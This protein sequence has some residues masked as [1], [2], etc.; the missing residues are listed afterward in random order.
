VPANR[1]ASGE[2]R[3]RI[4]AGTYAIAAFTTVSAK[5]WRLSEKHVEVRLRVMNRVEVPQ[6]S[7]VVMEP[8][9]V[10]GK[11]VGHHEREDRYSPHTGDVSVR[12]VE[13]SET[14]PEQRGQRRDETPV[15]RVEHRRA[16]PVPRADET[17]EVS[18]PG[19]CTRVTCA[20]AKSSRVIGRQATCR[21][22]PR[23]EPRGAFLAMRTTLRAE[24]YARSCEVLPI[25]AAFLTFARSNASHSPNKSIKSDNE[26]IPLEQKK[27]LIFQLAM[28]IRQV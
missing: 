2:L 27:Q 20:R 26:V 15:E 16:P 10:P 18:A 7:D 5:C 21:S 14:G 25:A 9:A 19:G 28:S 11:K 6:R 1:S 23:L 22:L 8:V 3:P 12:E 13:R 17:N 24:A 4:R